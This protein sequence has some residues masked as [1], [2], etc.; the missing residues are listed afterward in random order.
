MLMCKRNRRVP[1]ILVSLLFEC[2]SLILAVFA[3][4]S[5]LVTDS[6]VD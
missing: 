2:L 4:I 1:E 6:C 5:A 3:T